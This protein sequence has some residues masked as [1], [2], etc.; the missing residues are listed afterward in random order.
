[1]I[2]QAGFLLLSLVIL[3]F[4]AE[5]SLDAAERIGKKMGLSPLVIGMLLIGFG[6]SLPEFF[7]SHLAGSRGH[8]ELALGNIIGSNLANF[9][10]VLGVAGLITPL[11]LKGKSLFSQMTWHLFLYPFLLLVLFLGEISL[12]GGGILLLY[13]IIFF[14]TSWKKS[15]GTVTELSEESD[16]LQPTAVT[17]LLFLL[18]LAFLYAG[19]ELLVGSGTELGKLLGISDY[20]ISAIFVAF[21]TSFPELV[22]AVMACL[23][24]KETEMVI[25]NILGSNIFNISLVMG[26]LFPYKIQMTSF[27]PVEVGVLILGAIFLMG[28]SKKGLTIGREV[29][30]AFLGIYL[31][32]IFYWL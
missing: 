30:V 19:G 7:V 16:I 24:K 25:G 27:Y 13:F 12:I 28:L 15:K 32:M 31:A 21:G 4:G 17:Y 8:G 6:T 1:M 18:G 20:V 26:S 9:F 5:F 3:Y 22:T 2:E 23:K 29:G 10:L 14:G 11:K